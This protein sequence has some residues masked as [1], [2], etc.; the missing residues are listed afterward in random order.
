MSLNINIIES[1]DT[2]RAWACCLKPAL[3][4]GEGGFTVIQ[5]KDK[6]VSTAKTS[7]PSKNL[8]YLDQR[9]YSKIIF[10]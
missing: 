8:G 5:I 4:T 10:K 6:T 7:P 9:L 3:K 2:L 1:V